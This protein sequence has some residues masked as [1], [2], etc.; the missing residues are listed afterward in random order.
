MK[1]IISNNFTKSYK[2][3]LV[4][5]EYCCD[6]VR[7]K[8]D[9]K[10]IIDALIPIVTIAKIYLEESEIWSRSI[11]EGVGIGIFEAIRH[12]DIYCK[13]RI[14]PSEDSKI[15]S[16]VFLNSKPD[17]I[18]NLDISRG[19][20]L[21]TCS[22]LDEDGSIQQVFNHD[23]F[24]ADK[25]LPPLGHFYT[26]SNTTTLNVK[27]KF[28]PFA[29]KYLLGDLVDFIVDDGVSIKK[30]LLFEMKAILSKDLL[31]GKLLVSTNK[32][33]YIKILY[34]LPDQLI[35]HHI[36]IKI[37]Y[38]VS[39]EAML[40]NST[41]GT[42]DNLQDVIFASGLVPND[43]VT[44]QS[45]E[46]KEQESIIVQD[47]ILGIQNVYDSLCSSMR[48]NLLQDSSLIELCEIHN[49]SDDRKILNLFSS[50]IKTEFFANLKGHISDN[51]LQNNSGTQSITD[52][53]AI[54]LNDSCNYMSFTP[55][56]QDIACTLYASLLNKELF[57]NFINIDYLFSLI[58]FNNNPQLQYAFAR[59]LEE[60]A[61]NFN[62]ELGIDTTCFLVPELFSQILQPVIA[63]RP[64][65]YRDF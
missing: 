50:K 43:M 45:S 37:W 55:V 11:L 12:S 35:S 26:F 27:E 15:S 42:K 25:C 14:V 31:T 40:L 2:S 23:Y 22:V 62:L 34:K 60:E 44:S 59:T 52:T 13:P 29:E 39:I 58:H 49:T 1:D 47:E 24:I 36:D 51:V 30:N 4:T 10:C 17:I 33:K 65:C 28:I 16:S 53:S 32:P 3:M 21:F 56:L 64:L 5:D 20:T 19:S 8:D 6:G 9:I 57:G 38:V 48:H 46:E 41:M 7:L 61:D 63:Q 18:I 54:K